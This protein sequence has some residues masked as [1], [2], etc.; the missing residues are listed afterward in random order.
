MN[1]IKSPAALLGLVSY[2]GSKYSVERWLLF[3]LVIASLDLLSVFQMKWRKSLSPLKDRD[4]WAFNEVYE[5][6]C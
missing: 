1:W 6:I 3:L 2:S 5:E 4:I